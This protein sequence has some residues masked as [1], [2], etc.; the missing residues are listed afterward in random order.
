MTDLVAGF[1]FHGKPMA[2]LSCFSFASPI[3]DQSLG[4]L[5]TFK[6]GF[7]MKIPEREMFIG[8]MWGTLLVPL[9]NY[10]T[11]R[12]VIDNIDRDVLKGVKPSVSWNA[13]GTRAWYSASVLWGI[14]G[15]QRFFGKGSEYSFVYYGVLIGVAT[16]LIAYAIQR[17]KP[18][19]KTEEYFNA[20][21]FFSSFGDIPT[22][23]MTFFFSAFL[24]A[25]FL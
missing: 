3:L 5:A 6:F 21:V 9:V 12:L 13:L 24:F 22:S 11:M 17:W 14:I 4:L 10:G 7:Y 8:Q 16:V 18:S 2:V 1:I 25:I 23:P 20:P 19:W 15:P